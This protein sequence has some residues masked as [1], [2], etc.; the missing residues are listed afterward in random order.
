MTGHCHWSETETAVAWMSQS[1]QNF[2]L[3][4]KNGTR[5]RKCSLCLRMYWVARA[6][7]DVLLKPAPAVENC[8]CRWARVCYFSKTL[9]SQRHY[10]GWHSLLRRGCPALTPSMFAAVS[11]TEIKRAAINTCMHTQVSVSLQVPMT[12]SA[13][14]LTRRLQWVPSNRRRCRTLFLF[15]AQWPRS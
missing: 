1:V 3:Y 13:S 15:S 7:D 5:H 8:W 4:Q 6:F 2:I 14:T 12:P 11:L 10:G 9:R